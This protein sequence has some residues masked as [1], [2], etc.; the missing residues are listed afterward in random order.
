VNAPAPPAAPTLALEGLTEYEQL[1]PLWVTVKLEVPTLMVPI[2]D[3]T[4]VFRS[5]EYWMNPL[6][7]LV[8]EV[9]VIQATFAVGFHAQPSGDRTVI[10]PEPPDDPTVAEV[11]DS[12]VVQL[13]PAWVT[14]KS[15]PETERLPTR[16]FMLGFGLTV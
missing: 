15:V 14:W 11:G 8:A 5:T 1:K 16:W 7:V 9:M 13:E 6:P 2:R 3:V 12:E 10:E 4:L